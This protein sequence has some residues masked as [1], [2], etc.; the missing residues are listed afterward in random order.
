MV[1]VCI[2]TLMRSHA[3][4]HPMPIPA[5]CANEAFKLVTSCATH[6]NNYMMYA[7]DV[8]VYTYTFE[9]ERKEDCP[10]C[11]MFSLKLALARDCTLQE[12]IDRVKDLPE[13]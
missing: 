1:F 12:L 4:A 8:G 11:G 2:L 13:L 6:L 5:S 9:L 10:V 7:G 3:Y